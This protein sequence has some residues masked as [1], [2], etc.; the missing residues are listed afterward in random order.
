MRSELAESILKQCPIIYRGAKLGPDKNLMCFGFECGSGWFEMLILLSKSIE[1]IASR[2]KAKG[3][4][5]DKLPL[6]RQVKEKFGGLRYYIQNSND[7]INHL[8]RE[9]E[10]KSYGIC[11]VCGAAG[12]LRVIEGIY[13]TRCHEHLKGWPQ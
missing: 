3:V 12:D 7:E 9:A 10:E 2:L 8:I 1:K 5:D 13:M 4:D 6:A 11:D